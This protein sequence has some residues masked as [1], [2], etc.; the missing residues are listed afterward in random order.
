MEI[1]GYISTE[2]ITHE[3]MID[4]GT[5]GQP[6][7]PTFTC[8][9]SR[10]ILPEKAQREAEPTEWT[11]SRKIWNVTAAHPGVTTRVAGGELQIK[12]GKEGQRE[13][14]NNCWTHKFKEEW[15]GIKANER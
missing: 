15:A 2:H 13:I 6:R 12:D 8:A 11:E 4:D 10:D 5:D 7:R 14:E 9:N 3:I 1:H